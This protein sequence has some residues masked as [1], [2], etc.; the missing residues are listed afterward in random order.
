MRGRSQLRGPSGAQ[1]QSGIFSVLWKGLNPLLLLLVVLGTVLIGNSFVKITVPESAKLKVW[2]R[3]TKEGLYGPVKPGYFRPLVNGSRILVTGAAGFIGMQLCDQLAARMQS[4]GMNLIGIDDFNAYYP[5]GLKAARARHLALRHGIEVINGSVC[6]GRLLRE[7]LRKHRVTHVVHLAAQAGVRYSISHPMTYVQK[8][9]QCFVELME[10][11]VAVQPRPYLVYASSSSVYGLNTHIPFAESDSVDRPGNLYAATKRN[12]EEVAFA[13][14]NIYGLPSVGLRFFTVYGPWGRPDMA[15]YKFAEKIKNGQPIMV[16]NDGSM[17]RDFTY[18]DDIVAGVIRAME[19]RD[20]DGHPQIF[21]LGN[22]QPETVRTLI[23]IL[24]KA[25]DLKATV[26]DGG[27]SKGEVP[28]T[29]ADV[30]LA[31]QILHYSP[32]TSLEDGVTR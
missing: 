31:G 19:W 20:E 16:Y 32:T 15:V 2:A 26:V 12:N 18:V 4:P 28:T 1:E 14:H 11:I 17:R 5:V 24:E 29:F 8:N 9:V 13:Y 23:K 22:N 30:S 25:M 21:N 27:E 3:P 10:A 7:L 6:D